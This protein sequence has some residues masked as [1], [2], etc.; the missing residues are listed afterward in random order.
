MFSISR[1]VT[2][3]TDESS[4]SHKFSIMINNPCHVL[5]KIMCSTS[6]TPSRAV[7]SICGSNTFH[8]ECNSNSNPLTVSRVGSPRKA[9]PSLER[10]QLFE[11]SILPA[12]R[13]RATP[14][15]KP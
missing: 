5:H 12:Y 10:H 1:R 7:I 2:H 3:F 15:R 4:R 6:Y 13:P 9:P 14:T 11:P 8:M